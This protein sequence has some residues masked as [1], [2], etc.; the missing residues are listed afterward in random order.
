MDKNP[1]PPPLPSL[2]P[3]DVVI[4]VPKRPERDNG[5][6]RT[7]SAKEREGISLAKI[8]PKKPQN[9]PATVRDV[10]SPRAGS[11]SSLVS[12][13][14]RPPSPL[15]ARARFSDNFAEEKRKKEKK[16]RENRE[17]ER[18]EKEREKEEDGDLEEKLKKMSRLRHQ[19]ALEILTSEEHYLSSLLL[20]RELYLKPFE[21][22]SE[23]TGSKLLMNKQEM[24]LMFGSLEIII[25]F[26]KAL[27][28]KLRTSVAPNSEE[29][30][31]SI[32]L[33]S[34][35]TEFA[36]Y[37]KV[38]KQY[39][40]NYDSSMGKLNTLVAS[41]PQLKKYLDCT[42]NKK[43]S[44]GLSL[45]DYLIMPVQRVPRYCL[46]LREVIRNT[47]EDHEDYQSLQLALEKV[48]HLAGEINESKRR[49]EQQVHFIK[50]QNRLMLTCNWPLVPH[51]VYEKEWSNVVLGD[52]FMDSFF[53]TLILFNDILL[54]C[55]IVKGVMSLSRSYELRGAGIEEV[56]FEK[57]PPGVFLLRSK[58]PSLP[59]KASSSSSSSP[60]SS[61]TQP[62]GM[63]RRKSFSQMKSLLTARPADQSTSSANIK[64][65]SN[66]N[67]SAPGGPAA[68][69]LRFPHEKTVFVVFDSKPEKEEFETS[70]A[71]SAAYSD[72]RTVRVVETTSLDYRIRESFKGVQTIKFKGTSYHFSFN[73][74][75]L[76]DWLVANESMDRDRAY[77]A[78]ENLL[79]EGVFKPCEMKKSHGG[80][81]DKALPYRFAWHDLESRFQIIKE[82]A[83]QPGA[84]FRFSV[85]GHSRSRELED[86][87]KLIVALRKAS[88][89]EDRMDAPFVKSIE[90]VNLYFYWMNEKRLALDAIM[91]GA[92]FHEGDHIIWISF[93][94]AEHFIG[95][96]GDLLELLSESHMFVGDACRIILK[97]ELKEH[98]KS[99]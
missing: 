17:K 62:S 67:L 77:F 18:R 61:R 13:D 8:P 9:R 35:F 96:Y 69:R 41:R 95:S 76:I 28:N 90:D 42:Q 89:M 21:D 78:G 6:G 40:D 74:N 79:K 33:S 4:S 5:R 23:E 44:K 19:A 56:S 46:L 87:E 80:F 84:K 37:L 7:K 83:K 88:A 99:R 15:P 72:S 51:R 30:G 43:E 66:P 34:V 2:P 29:D 24:N 97:K 71:K 58:N 22:S 38:Y 70:Y 11:S 73:G 75:E 53:C 36:A 63:K 86:T 48:Q 16:E 49:M 45:F 54:I 85:V 32:L 3:M 98:K 81:V 20:V 12:S 50:V 93:D 92:R 31:R 57:I 47:L 14:Q 59:S 26:S 68:V 60:S 65:G 27:Y 52:P 82:V 64:S 91:P 55:P 39:T 94:R 10:A 25:N 1:I